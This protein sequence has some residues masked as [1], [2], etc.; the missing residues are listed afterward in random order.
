MSTKS[1]PESA[2]FQLEAVEEGSALVIKSVPSPQ[3]AGI[4]KITYLSVDDLK[5]PKAWEQAVINNPPKPSQLE[6]EKKA[7]DLLK[8]SQS[9]HAQGIAVD[10]GSEKD[11]SG[12]L[13]HGFTPAPTK[14]FD[15]T[16]IEGELNKELIETIQK[17]LMGGLGMPQ[18]LGVQP[19]PPQEPKDR[20]Q[21]LVDELRAV[22]ARHGAEKAPEVVQAL[23]HLKDALRSVQKREEEQKALPPG[24]YVDL[25]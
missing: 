10:F 6:L 18:P 7:H 4:Q 16:K 5:K 19:Q 9:P 2:E 20:A 11:W 17:S 15:F 14:P 24:R 12:M 21:R 23:Q 1:T 25:T 22:L 8:K 3:P 13:V